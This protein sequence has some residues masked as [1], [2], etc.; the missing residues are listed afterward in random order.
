MYIYIYI[1]PFFFRFFSHIDYHR[2]LGRAEFSLQLSTIRTQR[3]LCED[4]GLILGLAPWVKD[5]ALLQ[6]ASELAEVAWIWRCRGCGGGR[7]LQL[8]LDPQP[9]NF[10]SQKCGPKKEKKKKAYWGEFPVL[11]SRSQRGAYIKVRPSG[12]ALIWDGSCPTG[13]GEHRRESDPLQAKERGL[14]RN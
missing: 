6:A 2:I 4:V 3:Y 12:W 1:P 8:Q 9:G 14:R 5:L 13:G 11:Y 10:H 7:Q